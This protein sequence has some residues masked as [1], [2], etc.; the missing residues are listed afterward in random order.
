MVR[1]LF[2]LFAHM[3]LAGKVFAI[4]AKFCVRAGTVLRPKQGMKPCPLFTFRQQPIRHT[5]SFSI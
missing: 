3:I 1:F 4:G 2:D 5:L